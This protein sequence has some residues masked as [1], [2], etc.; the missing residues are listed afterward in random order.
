MSCKEIEKVLISIFRINL[1]CSEDIVMRNIKNGK[2]GE[3]SEFRDILSEQF[4][5][6]IFQEQGLCLS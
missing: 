2:T 1:K 6:R 4:P 3:G 5:F